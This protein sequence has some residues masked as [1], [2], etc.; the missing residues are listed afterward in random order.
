MN[1]TERPILFIFTAIYTCIT[2]THANFMLFL[3]LEFNNYNEINLYRYSS[4]FSNLSISYILISKIFLEHSSANW[5]KK[6]NPNVH[7][8]GPQS[9]NNTSIFSMTWGHHSNWSVAGRS[10]NLGIIHDTAKEV[11]KTDIALQG[12]ITL[13]LPLIRA[14]LGKLWCLQ[15]EKICTISCLSLPG[16]PI[17]SIVHHLTIT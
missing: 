4:T 3:Q 9:L 11:K 14:M 1:L 7:K 5:R 15:V 8:K 12:E 16:L 13:S 17:Y 6:I 2:Q 10:G